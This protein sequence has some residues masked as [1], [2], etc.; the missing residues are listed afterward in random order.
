MSY[1]NTQISLLQVQF[2]RHY[3]FLIG[4]M[5]S[6][7]TRLSLV[8]VS[9]ICSPYSAKLCCHSFVI[10]RISRLFQYKYR[11]LII[12]C[13][14]WL[15]SLWSIDMLDVEHESTCIITIKLHVE[16]NKR[17]YSVSSGN[18]LCSFFAKIYLG[19][20]LIQEFLSW[21]I[22]YYDMKCRTD[23]VM[24]EH[25]LSFYVACCNSCF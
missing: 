8:G 11:N 12:S 24:S 18:N 15:Q 5:P 2:S 25:H 3:L 22:S 19:R 20:A 16:R 23:N 1:V 7:K 17:F 4:C 13:E 21:R 14:W 9:Q 6:V 10:I